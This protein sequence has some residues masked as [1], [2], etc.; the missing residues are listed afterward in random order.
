MKLLAKYSKD[1][2]HQHVGLNHADFVET[3]KRCKLQNSKSFKKDALDTFLNL[4]NIDAEIE[5]AKPS[6]MEGKRYVIR[7]GPKQPGY[8]K[9]V[10]SQVNSTKCTTPRFNELASI[11]RTFKNSIR[12]VLHGEDPEPGPSVDPEPAPAP[13][14]DSETEAGKE[15]NEGDDDEEAE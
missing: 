4:H 10:L 9:N 14:V 11:R 3:L 5:Y 8:H 6:G 15:D 12:E 13:S 2:L 7:I 1:A